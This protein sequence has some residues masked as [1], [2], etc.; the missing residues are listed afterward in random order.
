ML[1]KFCSRSG[2]D[3]KLFPWRGITVMQNAD[4]GW[5]EKGN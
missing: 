2:A 3:K 5:K 4:G 1:W